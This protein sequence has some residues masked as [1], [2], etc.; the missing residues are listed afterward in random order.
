MN[1][2][3]KTDISAPTKGKQ[4]SREEYNE[5]VKKKMQ[6]MREMFRSRRGRPRG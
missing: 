1:P 2:E 4:V 3:E 5:I 6:E